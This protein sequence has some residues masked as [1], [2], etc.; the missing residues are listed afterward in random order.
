MDKGPKHLTRSGIVQLLKQ[1]IQSEPSGFGDSLYRN[2][3]N[4]DKSQMFTPLKTGKD[5]AAHSWQIRN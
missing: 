2:H 3:E 5:N 1:N 4:S